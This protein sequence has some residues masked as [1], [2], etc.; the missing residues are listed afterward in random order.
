MRNY[1]RH[2]KTGQVRLVEAWFDSG[3]TQ[4]EFCRQED[5][6]KSTFGSWLRKYKKGYY[7]NTSFAGSS[8]PSFLPVEVVG[9]QMQQASFL[10]QVTI[11]FP[12]GVQVSCA[13]GIAMGQLKSLI[14]I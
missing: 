6:S 8:L 7:R 13:S 2:N 4:E 10:D 3:Q 11:N 14:Q 12:N 1:S 5:L 9:E